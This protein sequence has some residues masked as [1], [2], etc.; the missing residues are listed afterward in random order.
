V[1]ASEDARE[2]LLDDVVLA[3]DDFSQ[4]GPDLAIQVAELIDRL[5]VCFLRG[6]GG[7]VRGHGVARKT[8]ERATEFTRKVVNLWLDKEL[9]VRTPETADFFQTGWFNARNTAETHMRR[10][11]RMS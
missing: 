1:A 3:D 4:L 9:G 7:R 5:D 11:A 10:A 8:A 6:G 2:Q